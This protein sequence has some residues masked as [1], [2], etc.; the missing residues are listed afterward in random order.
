MK[1]S[2]FEIIGITPEMVKTLGDKDLFTLIKSNYRVLQSIYHPDKRTGKRLIKGGS[3]KAAEI[4]L[5]FEK[6]NFEKNEESF[7]KHKEQYVNRLYRGLKR[8]VNQLQDQVKHMDE[9]ADFMADS[10]MRFIVMH[11]NR[12]DGMHLL[13]LRNIRLG[14]HDVAVRYNLRSSPQ[15]FGKN[16]KEIIFDQDGNMFYK[17][18]GRDRF[19]PV[20]HI[21]LIGAVDEDK[22][23]LISIL[24]K[25]PIKTPSLYHS[26]SRQRVLRTDQAFEVNNTIHKS[27]FKRYCLPHLNPEI[28]ERSYLFSM[29]LNETH[30]DGQICLEGMLV[31]VVRTDFGD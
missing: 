8:V 30:D 1:K 25:N 27:N 19:Q 7:R 15:A 13:N 12:H 10:F 26:G 14:L 22:I 31:K 20:S 5:S 23:D 11:I 16:Y 17:L 24:N 3:K 4:N 2:P 28:R 18:Q 6:V 29:H 9:Q 21:K